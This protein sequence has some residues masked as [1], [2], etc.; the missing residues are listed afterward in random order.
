CNKSPASTPEALTVAS[1][2]IN[3]A[4]SSFSNWGTCVDLFAPGGNITSAWWNSNTATNTI[5]GT[6]MASPHVAGVA[7]LYLQ[8]SPTATPA[9]VGAQILASTTPSR[10]T[11]IGTGSPNRLLFS[12]LTAPPPAPAFG[13]NPSALSFTFVR[14]VNGAAVQADAAAAEAPRQEF[15]ATGEGTPKTAPDGLGQ[16][17]EATASSLVLT[18]RALLSNTGTAALV[19]TSTSNRPWLTA[20]PTDGT[21]NPTHT[22]YVNATVNAA[23]LSTGTHTGAVTVNGPAGAQA[24]VDVTVNVTDALSLVVGTPRTGQSGTLSSLKYYAVNVPA[25]ATSLTI[26]TSGGTGDVDLYVRYGNVPTM[27]AFDCRPFMGGNVETCQVNA[28]LPGT[29]YVMLHGWSA[30]SGVTLAATSGGTPASPVNLTA[31]PTSLAAIHLTWGD[32]SVNETGFTVSRRALQLPSNVWTAWADVGSPGPNATTFTNTGLVAGTLYQFR[33]RA[34]NAAGCSAW[35]TGGG[36]TI[37]TE[38]PS[39]PFNL[40]ATATSGTTATVTWTDGSG[41]ETSFSMMRALRN[42]DGTWGAYAAVASPSTDAVAFNNAGLLP[43][44]QYRY[45]LQACNPA[46]CSAWTV[47]NIVVMPSV[48]PPPPA[49]TATTL[50]GSSIRVQWTD[51]SANETSFVL[52]RATVTGGNVVGNFALVS[53]LSPNLVLYNNTGMTAGTYQYRIRACNLAGCSAWATTAN[54]VIPPVPTAPASASAVALSATSVR[55]TWPDAGSVETS[56]QVYRALRNLDGT[57][58]A[59]TA[60]TTLPANT[61]LYNNLSLLSGRAYRYQVRACNLSGCSGFATSNIVS[62]VAP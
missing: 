58:P 28:P 52:Q 46:G 15:T 26:G 18:G 12:L 62:T 8:G 13:L 60:F 25:G 17:H 53:V 39:P 61:V 44:R 45:Q 1:S 54:V 31:R 3:D 42:V 59:F 2:E 33:V 21:L 47:S 24:G 9:T 57:W 5:S 10:V 29:Y 7:A 14:T 23:G 38:A 20:D 43:G 27:S 16:G 19:W 22:A 11:N 4:R 6:S 49:I 35:L 55:L 56:Y 48:P 30:Y 51:G 50:S 36:V 32:G 40:V 41:N 34:C 37:P